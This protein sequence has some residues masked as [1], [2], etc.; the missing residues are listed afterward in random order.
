MDSNQDLEAMSLPQLVKRF[1]NDIRYGCHSTR[2]E[3]SRSLAGKELQRRGKESLQEI[4][5]RWGAID[6]QAPENQ[7]EIGVRN[8]LAMLIAWIVGS[9]ILEVTQQAGLSR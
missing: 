4:A 8:G 5:A 7:V 9:E 6:Q 2:A 1:E 3:A